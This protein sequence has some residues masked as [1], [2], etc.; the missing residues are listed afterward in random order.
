M[1]G[2][3]IDYDIELNEGSNINE[4]ELEDNEKDININF[5]NEKKMS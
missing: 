5:P 2:L 1:I 3:Y 4:D